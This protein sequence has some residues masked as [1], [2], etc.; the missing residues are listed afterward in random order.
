MKFGSI[1]CEALL[2]DFGMVFKIVKYEKWMWMLSLCQKI[3]KSLHWI[4][5][6]KKVL[7]WFYKGF[8]KNAKDFSTFEI[9][10][11]FSSLKDFSGL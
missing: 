10:T 4:E 11:S 7:F 1:F 6:V 9:W 3:W 8:S 5:F 2:K